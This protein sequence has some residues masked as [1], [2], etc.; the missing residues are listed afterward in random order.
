MKRGPKAETP[1][2]KKARNTL[3]PFRDAGK[4]EIIVPGSPP[5]Q[6]DYLSPEA[7]DVWQEVI[8][9]VMAARVTEI[10]SSLLARYCSLE[11]LVRA[12]FKAEEGPPPPAAYLSELRKCEELLG[13][14]GPKSRVAGGPPIGGA[15]TNPFARNGR[16]PR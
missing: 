3:R 1:T 7:I 11:A 9:R 4:Q 14:A 15:A 8:G 2:T 12:S 6:P 5:Q 13:I 10:D 16:A